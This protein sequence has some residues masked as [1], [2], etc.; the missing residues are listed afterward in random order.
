MLLKNHE[1]IL[2]IW[3]YIYHFEYDTLNCFI[4][5]NLPRHG[6]L[7]KLSLI[8][9]WTKNIWETNIN[10]RKE[11]SWIFYNMKL[12]VGHGQTNFDHG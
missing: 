7:N 10:C 8:S 4:D 1:Q 2:F 6:E 5:K 9:L 12:Q 3:Y 11:T